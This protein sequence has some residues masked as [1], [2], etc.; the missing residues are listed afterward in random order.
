MFQCLH[1]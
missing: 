1:D